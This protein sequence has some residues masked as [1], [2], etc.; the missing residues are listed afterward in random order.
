MLIVLKNLVFTA[1]DVVFA[2][3]NIA[4]KTFFGYRLAGLMGFFFD[5]FQLVE[6]RSG[7][8]R[9]DTRVEQRSCSLVFLVFLRTSCGSLDKKYSVSRSGA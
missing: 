7:L 1:R 6:E 4:H 9:E 5:G 2:D 3:G 8:R